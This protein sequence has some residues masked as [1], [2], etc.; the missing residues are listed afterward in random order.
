MADL[1]VGT[2]HKNIG[3]LARVRLL[4]VLFLLFL[5]LLLLSPFVVIVIQGLVLVPMFFWTRFDC[6]QG[7]K[8]LSFPGVIIVAQ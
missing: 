4:V 5:S 7:F 6:I 1:T 3:G 8:A 2:P